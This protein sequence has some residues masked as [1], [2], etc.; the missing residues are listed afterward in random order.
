M[1]NHSYNLHT[2]VCRKYFSNML[3]KQEG[4]ARTEAH[5]FVWYLSVLH[6]GTLLVMGDGESMV[7]GLEVKFI[8]KQVLF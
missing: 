4:V 2:P 3:K 6:E 1:K 5:L 7:T 8:K